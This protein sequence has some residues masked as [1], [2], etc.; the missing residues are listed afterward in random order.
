MLYKCYCIDLIYFRP[1]NTL[2]RSHKSLRLILMSF[3]SLI[4]MYL[5]KQHH[6]LNMLHND[7]LIV[8]NY[9]HRDLDNTQGYIYSCLPTVWRLLCS[10]YIH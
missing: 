9:L 10:L 6:L 4:F 5:T 3:R 2:H 1:K 8:H 7:Q